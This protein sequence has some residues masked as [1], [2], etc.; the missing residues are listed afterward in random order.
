VHVNPTDDQGH[1]FAEAASAE[2]PVFMLNLL[3]FKER[4][5]GVHEGEGISGAE[6]YA[7][8]AEATGAH[9]ARVGG[10]I[11]WAG[12]CGTALIGPADGEWDIAAVVRYPSRTAFLEMVGDPE[13]LEIA[14]HRTSG[15]ADSRLI[16][17]AEMPLGV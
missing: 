16:P 7:R 6:A 17:C 11:V 3:R 8:Y 9:L 10:Q 2:G 15:I 14:E 4:A 1:A 12:A 13:Y 5:D